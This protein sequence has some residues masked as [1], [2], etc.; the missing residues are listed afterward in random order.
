MD[1]SPHILLFMAALAA[2]FTHELDAVQCKEWRIFPLLSRLDDRTGMLWFIWLHVPLFGI[3]VWF[4][5][6]SIAAGGDAFSIGFSLFCVAHA[7]VHWA[8][9]RHPQCLFANA[10]SR[11]IIWGCAA[12]GAAALGALA[13]GG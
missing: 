8:Y 5:A 3:V 9:E 2:M 10:R 12:A 6:G 1:A 4:A 11:T 7:F 13:L